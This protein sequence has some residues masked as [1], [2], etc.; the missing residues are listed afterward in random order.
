V[1]HALAKLGGWSAGYLFVV[2]LERI[3]VRAEL[4]AARDV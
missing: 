1:S 2:L 4:E 3:V